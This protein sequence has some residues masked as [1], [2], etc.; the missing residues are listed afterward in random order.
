MDSLASTLVDRPEVQACFGGLLRDDDQLGFLVARGDV[1]SVQTEIALLSESSGYSEDAFQMQ[2]EPLLDYGWWQ[3]PGPVERPVVRPGML[4]CVFTMRFPDF[5][6]RDQFINATQH[7]SEYCWSNE[8][9]TQIYG[10]GVAYNASTTSAPVTE[11]DVVVVMVCTDEAALQKHSD[12]PQHL[13]LGEKVAG[14]GIEV[15]NPLSHVYQLTT[16]YLWRE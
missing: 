9:D 14:L 16:G 13:A 8:P 12:D 6:N 4:L 5:Q 11:G 3:R 15:E 1:S 10:M 2:L 7:H